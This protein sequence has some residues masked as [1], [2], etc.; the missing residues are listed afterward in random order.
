MILEQFWDDFGIILGSFWGPFGT[1]LESFWNHFELTLGSFWDDFGTIL[2]SFWKHFG[3]T[4]GLFWDPFCILRIQE[5]MRVWGAADFLFFYIC[6]LSKYEMIFWS[7]AISLFSYPMGGGL[8]FALTA[9][10]IVALGAR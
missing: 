4:L 8:Y 5:K 1:I 9:H 7:R 6:G 3:M 2:D 10:H